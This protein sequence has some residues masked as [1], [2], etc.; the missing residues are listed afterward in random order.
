MPAL[1]SGSRTYRGAIGAIPYHQPSPQA[2][3]TDIAA[4]SMAGLRGLSGP[5]LGAGE[6]YYSTSGRVSGSAST[7]ESDSGASALDWFRASLE[8]APDIINAARGESSASI[9]PSTSTNPAR[10]AELA[11]MQ[12]ERDAAQAALIEQGQQPKQW[13][14]GVDNTLV[15]VGLG[16]LFIG[17]IV[18]YTAR[19]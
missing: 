1:K 19:K 18:A 5:G 13:I 6:W 3:N 11:R 4:L 2:M 12:A 14:Q 10:E 8:A 17:G 16:L 7:D 15:V 9:G